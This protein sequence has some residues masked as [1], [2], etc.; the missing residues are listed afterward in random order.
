MSTLQQL[1]EGMNQ[2]W[3][4]LV[5]GWH[6]LY[7]RA[8]NSITRFTPHGAKGELISRDKEE[9]VFRSSGWGILAAEVFD[10][11]DQVVI[12][13]EA[14]GM[15]PNE[16]RLEVIDNMLVVR[17]E[18]QLQRERTEGRY[19]VSECAYGS[20]ERAIPLP[21]EVDSDKASARYKRGVLRVE[22]PKSTTRHSRRI[23]VD[24]H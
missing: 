1:R 10:N 14:P 18:K 2:A 21:D 23:K 19:H 4:T 12:R 15:E 6:E 20:F 3:D 5:D 8:A 7:Q 16:F 22:I 17:G 11:N 9:L 24:V 13:L